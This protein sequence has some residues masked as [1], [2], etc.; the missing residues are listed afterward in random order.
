M[1]K[2]EIFDLFEQATPFTE[3][4]AYQLDGFQ[5]SRFRYIQTVRKLKERL[6][7]EDMA[8]VEKAQGLRKEM[9]EDIAFHYFCEGVRLASQYKISET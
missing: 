2:Q 7:E 1:I 4:K 6:S 3:G 9:E 5:T 8:A